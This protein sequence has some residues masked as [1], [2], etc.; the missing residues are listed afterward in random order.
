[1]KIEIGWSLLVAATSTMFA[2]V[3]SPASAPPQEGVAFPDSYRSWTH[4]TTSVDAA[5][6]RGPGMQH[7]YAN[8]LAMQ[9]YRTGKFPNGS[10]IVFDRFLLDTSGTHTKA[11]ARQLVDLMEKDSVRFRDTGGWGFDE[12]VGDS[13]VRHAFPQSQ[14]ATSCFKCHAQRKDNDFVFT[15][16]PDKDRATP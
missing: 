8:A 12:F 3:I 5:G 15:K 11:G 16:F 6:P 13:R 14:A 4:V 1:M 7:I 9:G 2:F 10:I